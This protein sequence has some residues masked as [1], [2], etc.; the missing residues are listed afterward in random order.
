VGTDASSA[1]TTAALS[2]SEVQFQNLASIV[3]DTSGKYSQDDQLNAYN[4]LWKL[5]ITGN[6][7][8]M[9]ESD[10]KTFWNAIQNSSIGQLQNQLF[11]QSQNAVEAAWNSG[12]PTGRGAAAGAALVNFYNNL[13]SFNQNV[14]FTTSI[15]RIQKD[16]SQPYASADAWLSSLGASV[17]ATPSVTI[18]LSSAAQAALSSTAGG[19][20]S[21]KPAESA[22]QPTGSEASNSADAALTL[23]QNASA[24]NAQ[25][26]RSG[27]Q[28]P[29]AAG[30]NVQ[31]TI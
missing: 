24:P 27:I 11:Y 26:S 21:T 1:N 5:G 6:T 28:K 9:D 30:D 10:S 12:T 2:Q 22:V 8:G 18:T 17:P 16:G 13:S 31:T 15:N 23:L 25:N 20:G 14:F 29:Y 3:L 19:S 4:S 7:G